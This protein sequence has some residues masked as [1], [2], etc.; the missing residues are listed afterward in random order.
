MLV[1]YKIG[2]YSIKSK[3]IYFRE[4]PLGRSEGI[5]RTKLI[6]FIAIIIFYSLLK[7]L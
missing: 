4:S 2:L 5:N 1:Y 6:E 3:G 7:F